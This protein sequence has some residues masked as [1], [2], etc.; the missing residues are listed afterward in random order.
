MLIKPIQCGI[1]DPSTNSI[2]TIDDLQNDSIM[3]EAR[4]ALEELIKLSETRIYETLE[5][6]RIKSAYKQEGIFHYNTI[7]T[8]ELSSPYFVSGNQ[9]EDFEIILMHHKED[10]IKSIAI[11][12]FPNMDEKVARQFL[13]KK[14]IEKRKEREVSFRKLELQALLFD[15][16]YLDDNNRDYDKLKDIPSL[17]ESLD[18]QSLKDLRK[19]NSI[20][21]QKRLR[22]QQLLEEQEIISLSLS[23]LYQIS[24]KEKVAS[25]YQIER[26]I[27]LLDLTIAQLQLE[28]IEKNIDK[29]QEK[30]EAV[31]LDN[32]DNQR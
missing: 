13:Q 3:K 18:N 23:S 10:N 11:D 6:K 30:I 16:F 20:S 22:G 4:Y 27:K 24:I 28:K 25:D 31:I 14:I 15:N 5:L 2:E 7:M 29:D 1:R 21:L 9:T 32:G 26:A 19:K 12:E 17:L 8:I